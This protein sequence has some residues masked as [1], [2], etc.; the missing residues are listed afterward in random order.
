MRI[1]KKIPRKYVTNGSPLFLIP[2]IYV[3]NGNIV[4]HGYFQA[5]TSNKNKITGYES[6]KY[7]ITNVSQNHKNSQKIPQFFIFLCE[8]LWFCETLV[9]LY[10]CTISWDSYSVNKIEGTKGKFITKLI[11][12]IFNWE[13]REY[14]MFLE[15][16]NFPPILPDFYKIPKYSKHPRTSLTNFW[17][18]LVNL[19]SN[20]K[21]IGKIRG[22]FN[23]QFKFG[24]AER[25]IVIQIRLG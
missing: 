13:L 11:I 18:S 23:N 2:W 16:F 25:P 15:I 8:F 3:P 7:K 12:Q 22:F 4:F 24:K 9:I 14:S 10:L 17:D 19:K 1:G 6:H 5:P 20:P 21:R